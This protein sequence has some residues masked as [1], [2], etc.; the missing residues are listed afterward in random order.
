MKNNRAYEYCKKSIKLKTTPKYVKLQM[1]EF[2]KICDGKDKKYILS[3]TKLEQLNRILKILI[4]PKGLKAGQPLFDC[5][6]GYQWLFYTAILCVV[7]K[8]NK[9]K[10]N[11]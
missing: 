4:M 7:Y 9:N 3:E 11:S 8:E 10:N 5:T 2:I 6:C 1:K